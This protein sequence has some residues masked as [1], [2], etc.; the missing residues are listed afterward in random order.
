MRRPVS[1]GKT[2]TVRQVAAEMGVEI[3]EYSPPRQPFAQVRISGVPLSDEDTMRFEDNLCLLNLI[4][5]EEE[6]SKALS[7]LLEA[8]TKLHSGETK[9]AATLLHKVEKAA[10]EAEAFS[11]G[12]RRWAELVPSGTKLPEAFVE[13]DDDGL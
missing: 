10:R 4:E 5:A 13:Y 6:L 2:D 12:L 1:I 9:L 3:Q 11:E 8:K 7:S